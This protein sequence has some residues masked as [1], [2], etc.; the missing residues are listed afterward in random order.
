MS[1]LEEQIAQL[2]SAIAA[3]EGLR[4]SVGDAVVE[5]TLTALRSR[6][7]S[8]LAEQ[9]TAGQVKVG[10]SSEA[11]LKQLQSYIPK[12]LA[13]KMRASGQIEGE[14]RQV[15]VLFADISGFTA[16]SERLDPEDVASLLNDCLHELVQAVYQYE[17]MV[18]KF[19]GD[20]IMAVFGAPVALED[21]AENALRAAL[22]MRENLQGFNRR[23]IEKL[24][25]PLDLHIG[26][27]TGVVIAGNMGSDLQM[28]YTVMGDTVNV[29][30][31]L[32]DAAKRGQTFVSRTTYRLTRGAFAF[33]E[34]DPIQVKGK[35]D[36]LQVYELLRAKLQPDK[37]RGVE[38]LVS[39]LVGRDHERSILARCLQEL[40]EG[41]GKIVKIL[42]EAGIGKSRLLAEIRQCEGRDLTWLEG[43]SFAFSRALSYSPFLDLLRRHA[44]IADEDGEAEARA[45]LRNRL[46]EIF[47]GEKDVYPVLAQLL[48][49][50]LEPGE[51]AIVAAMAGEAFRSR[52]FAILETFLL[53]L[54]GQKP[55]VL[56][57]EDLHWADLSS[58]DLMA[59]LL[60]VTTRAPIAFVLLSRPRQEAAG[61]WEKLEP[62]LAGFNNHTV[63]L[64]LQPLS[65]ESNHD[66]LKGLLGSSVLPEKLTAKIIEKA[67]GN[68]FFVEE[69]LRSLIERG[70]LAREGS[71]W[72]VTELVETIQ[73]PDTL[74]GV[75][76]SRLDRLPEGTRRVI[77]KAAVIGRVFLYR[78]L[79][80][81]AQGETDLDAQISLLEDAELVRERARHPEIEYIF[82]HALTQEVAY[83]T[84]LG[85]SRKMLHHKVGEA[86]EAVFAE[87]IGEFTGLLAYHYFCG[88]AW[89]K[90]LE[91]SNRA[92]DNAVQLY[93]YAEARG[94]YQHALETLKHLPDTPTHRQQRVDMIVKL[95]NVS[96]QA[97]SPEKNLALLN[98]AEGV[99]QALDDPGRMARVQL[100][101]G[102]VHYLAGRLRE[103]IAY[104]QKV[105][106]VAPG[107]ADP[108]LL[109]L[110]GAVIGRA[111][112]LQGQFA[113]ARQ[114]LEQSVPLLEAM[115]NRHE[116]L[117]ACLYRGASRACLGDYQ[118]GWV[119]MNGVLKMA[120]VSRNQNAETM[121]HTGMALIQ[122][123]A[124]KYAEAIE[125]AGQALAIA[126]KSGD[127]MFRYSSNSF[128]AWGLTGQGDYAGAIRHWTEAHKAAEPL[129]GRLLLGEWLTA[130]ESETLLGAGDAI[131]A[132]KR[133][134]EALAIAKAAGSVVA[135]GLA[136]RAIGRALAAGAPPRW[137][138]AET[139]LAKAVSLLETIGAKFELARAFLALGQTRIARGD[140]PGAAPPLERAVVLA[141]ECNLQREEQLARNLLAGKETGRLRT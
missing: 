76:L 73:V 104:F 59:H 16:L 139:H 56:V 67:E 52:L 101:M 10:L 19:V 50:R 60:S 118:A 37:M 30:A 77:Q 66:L 8:L 110:P 129:G 32:Q 117:F 62:A 98:E 114:L 84:L 97:E 27:N 81:M 17:G 125:N 107:L 138:E 4:S 34:M 105:M 119:D 26:V 124:G 6:L 9:K 57:M 3:Q 1:S 44:G 14:R 40:N 120:Q 99:A 96:L 136:E 28:S 115:K 78:V 49:L 75:L 134:E 83:Q 72:K 131:A 71:E 35:R 23:W 64:L 80:H 141:S 43:R 137:E 25:Q 90:A 108:E 29:A 130:I 24:G 18:D 69:V 55:L 38:G 86:M 88:E 47:P 109:A 132:L 31:R 42:G 58:V 63:E 87:R 94:H 51:T 15:T 127:A 33:Q 74:Q 11:L 103:A 5:V 2:R 95:V 65:E 106:A 91:Y 13:N 48:L 128:M 140:V 122:L 92:A 70:V 111:L 121:A 89:E 102:R 36:P 112:F 123:V 54:A 82:H 46:D 20:C 116:L 41:R 53:R 126:E 45:S 39:P 133:G 21:D 113:R 93:A 61:N 22:A 68:P 100:W 7:E 12:Q 79:N 135:E 85:P